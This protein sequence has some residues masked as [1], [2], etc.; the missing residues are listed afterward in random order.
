VIVRGS[1]RGY[2]E[3]YTFNKFIYVL[4][5]FIFF[6]ILLQKAKQEY[7]FFLH[8]NIIYE[9]KQRKKPSFCEFYASG[10]FWEKRASTRSYS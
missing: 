5:F 6:E 8:N 3:K 2:K 4:H 7:I 1:P 9:I 10:V